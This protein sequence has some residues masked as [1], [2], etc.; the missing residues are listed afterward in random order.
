MGRAADA[1]GRDRG[2]LATR[3]TGT[4]LSD[5][6]VLVV[7]G[8]DS[9]ALVVRTAEES[10]ADH[11]HLVREDSEAALCGIPRSALGPGEGGELVCSDCVD[12]LARRKTA[13]LAMKKI[14][15]PGVSEG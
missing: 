14:S 12:W 3:Y 6:L 7:A 13:S 9:R 15:R 4:S 2:L 1:A 10:L 11:A 8:A 5:N